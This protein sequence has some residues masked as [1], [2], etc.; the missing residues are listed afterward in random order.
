MVEKIVDWLT[1][2]FLF[3]GMVTVARAVVR[4]LFDRP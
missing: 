3:V 2:L 1:T 4:F